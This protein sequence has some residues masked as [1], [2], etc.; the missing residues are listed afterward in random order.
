MILEFGNGSRSPVH[1]SG[2]ATGTGTE[3][4]PTIG[5]MQLERFRRLPLLGIV[6]GAGL[7]DVDPLA[8]LAIDAGLES[9]EITMNTAG[10]PELIRRMARRA[11][12]SLMV[13]AGTVLD[14]DLLRSALDAGATFV[15]MPTLIGPVTEYCVTH[16]IPVFPGALTPTEIHHAHLAGATMVKVFPAGA[17]GPSYFKEVKGPFADI[18]LLAC[19][20]ISADNMAD[21]F[22]NGASAVAFGGSVFRRD[23]LAA[24]D[25][26][27]IAKEVGVLVE[28]CRQARAHA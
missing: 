10:A 26:P 8:D 17:F 22:R 9:I 28:A 13:G 20:G 19:G 4:R 23:W 3:N 16:G 7:D 5:R 14:L 21:Y 27:R 2:N 24:R 11:G 12:N 18:A 6:R 1:G 25:Y 15:V